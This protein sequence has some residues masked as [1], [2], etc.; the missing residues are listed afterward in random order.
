MSP[1]LFNSTYSKQN[2]NFPLMFHRARKGAS[3]NEKG[4][5]AKNPARG[6]ANFALAQRYNE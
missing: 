2:H 6:S 1:I 4:A 3:D 5:K